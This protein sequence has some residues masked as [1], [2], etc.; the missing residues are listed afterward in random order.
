M[1][2]LSGSV[3]R[4]GT[5]TGKGKACENDFIARSV[6][7]SPG[8]KLL[9]LR[10]FFLAFSRQRRILTAL[11]VA[12]VKNALDSA[13]RLSQS[14]VTRWCSF[15]NGPS[16]RSNLSLKS[17]LSAASFPFSRSRARRILNRHLDLALFRWQWPY[18]RQPGSSGLPVFF[19]C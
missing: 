11:I 16:D 6:K 19:A 1:T 14:F 17:W 3:K 10:G 13:V 12:F 9:T 8:F 4:R 5:Q 7:K 15:L 18:T 2:A